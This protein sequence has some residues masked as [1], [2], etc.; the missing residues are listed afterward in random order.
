MRTWVTGKSGRK[1]RAEAT[2]TVA[3]P[4]MVV[5]SVALFSMAV[6]ALAVAGLGWADFAHAASKKTRQSSSAS[7]GKVY[8]WVDNDGVVHFGDQIPPEYASIDR[9][10]LNQQ[11]IAVGTEQGTVTE[12]ELAAERQATAEKDATLAAAHR[13]EVLLN[14]YLS[15][16]EIEVL[17]DRRIGL[18]E[19]EIS[20]TTNYLQSLRDDLTELQAEASKFK[21]Y[22]T[23]PGAEPIDEKLAKE[24]SDTVDSIALYEKTLAN[25]RTRQDQVLMAF[26]AD[27]SRFKELKSQ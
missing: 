16:E 20:V 27:I 13:D 15:V 6:S 12:E 4:G 21:P 8:R 26:E 24:L 7:A 1:T 23:E 5:L 19:D 17:R 10:V 18:I 2:L 25:T 11:G 3:P 9:Q 22:S 14:T